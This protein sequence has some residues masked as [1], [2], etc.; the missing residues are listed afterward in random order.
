MKKRNHKMVLTRSLLT[1]VQIQIIHLYI[2]AEQKAQS[3]FL[4]DMKYQTEISKPI[5]H[6]QFHYY[7]PKQRLFPAI[8]N[9]FPF[10]CLGSFR[11]LHS[12]VTSPGTSAINQPP[13]LIPT[14]GILGLP[15]SEEESSGD[16]LIASSISVCKKKQCFQPREIYRSRPSACLRYRCL[17]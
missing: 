9:H 16:P 6:V 11:C 17:K 8:V 1:A 15:P 14:P 3:G 12:L 4:K 5:Y 10:T 2:Q 7:P 13:A